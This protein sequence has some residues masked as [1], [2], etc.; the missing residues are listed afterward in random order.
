MQSM[1]NGAFFSGTEEIPERKTNDKQQDTRIVAMYITSVGTALPENFYD[2]EA[3]ISQLRAHWAQRHHNVSRIEA[4]HRNAL[5]AGRHLALTLDE[6]KQLESFTD[7]N[8]AYIRCAVDLGMR[9]IQ[10]A[11]DRAGLTRQDIDHLFFVSVTGVAAPSIDARIINRMGLRSDIKRT[12]IFGMGCVAGAAGMTKLADY[13]KAYPDQVAVLLSVELCSLTIQREDLSIPNIVA[14]GLFGDGA[15][16]VVMQGENRGTGTPVVLA[17]RSFFYPDTEQ[18]MGW[19]I[20]E[21]GFRIVLSADVPKVA[22]E[23]VGP[24]VDLFLADQGLTRKDIG[25]YVCHPG[26]PKVL[27]AYQQSLGVTEKEM[28]V[29]WKSLREVGNMSSSS[30]LFVLRETMDH[31]RPPAGTYGLMIAMGPGFCSE[32]VLLKW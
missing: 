25:C 1:Y 32:L 31:H 11:L 10:D 23:H 30:I 12:P 17:T 19:N 28:A 29:T 20:T 4:I 8:D 27:E 9:A 15:A 22:L 21:Q 13:L 3:L 5:V 24:N 7:A 18:V 2:Q 6:Y 14:T 16:A 26:G